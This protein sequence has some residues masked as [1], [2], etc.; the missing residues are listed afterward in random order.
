MIKIYREK[1]E[2]NLTTIM[3][4]QQEIK[5]SVRGPTSAQVDPAS[6]VL[7]H[8]CVLVR[9]TV[10]NLEPTDRSWSDKVFGSWSELT[11]TRV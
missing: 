7:S 3:W 1:T 5:R 8:Q 4:G 2:S 9:D 6:L 11:G 10:G